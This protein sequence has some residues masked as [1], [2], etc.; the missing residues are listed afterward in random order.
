VCEVG[1]P[2]VAEDFLKRILIVD[3]EPAILLSFK[4]LLRFPDAQIETAATVDGALALL[5]SN[6]FDV[7][8]LDVRLTGSEGRE[9]LSLMRAIKERCPATHIILIT[10]Y[11]SPAVME[12]ALGLGADYYY[13]KPVSY[14][15]LREA[16]ISLGVAG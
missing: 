3:D 13:E 10:G 16:I 4:R 12:E 8:L 15:V 5:E 9:G 2:A 6:T 14:S 1:I 7:A 11:G